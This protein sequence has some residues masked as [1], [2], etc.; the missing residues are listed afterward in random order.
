MNFN[1]SGTGVVNN[2]SREGLVIYI[3]VR[4]APVVV[5]LMS[6]FL[7]PP[8]LLFIFIAALIG[9][10]WVV[11]SISGMQLIGLRWYLDK[12]AGQK[13]FAFYSKPDPYIP[14]VIDSNIFWSLFF[15][16]LF[17][18]SI[19]AIVEIFILSYFKAFL[20]SIAIAFHILNLSMYSKARNMAKKAIQKSVLDALQEEMVTFPKIDEDK[21]NSD[22]S[23]STE[24]DDIQIENIENQ[25]E[26]PNTGDS[27]DEDIPEVVEA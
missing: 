5:F 25:D 19:T 16:C 12:K 7:K 23:L 8:I 24:E 27:L 20:A 18:W 13:A 9:E 1:D 10:F 3:S 14:N 21:F 6:S 4:I 26:V 2:S 11:K 22:I 15:V 17:G